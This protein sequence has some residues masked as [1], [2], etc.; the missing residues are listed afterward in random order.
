[1]WSAL[2]FVITSSKH[3]LNVVLV[4]GEKVGD[5]AMAEIVW[6]DFISGRDL[7]RRQSPSTTSLNTV[8]L[9]ASAREH[10]HLSCYLCLT[11]RLD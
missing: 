3:P 6:S 4:V 9:R 5:S 7:I 1:M 8:H 11:E 2:F 10:M